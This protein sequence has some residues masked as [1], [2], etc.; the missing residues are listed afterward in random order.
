MMV[1]TYPY[2]Y[3]AI[4]VFEEVNKKSLTINWLYQPQLIFALSAYK[5]I[6]SY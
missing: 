3:L 2:V 4:T 1:Y 5:Q 6:F